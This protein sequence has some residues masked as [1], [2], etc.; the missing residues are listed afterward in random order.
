MIRDKALAALKSRTGIQSSNPAYE[1]AKR[2]NQPPR[3]AEVFA[4][5]AMVPTIFR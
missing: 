5:P 2:K 3:S 4:L 1:D